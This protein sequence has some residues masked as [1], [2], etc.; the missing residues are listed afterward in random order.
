MAGPMAGERIDY[1]IERQRHER[2]VGR[3]DLM[4][5]LDQL[6]AR[7]PIADPADRWVLV[8]GGPGMGKSA[9]LAW[10]LARRER[11]GDQV[12]HHFIHR[13][14]YGWD[15]PGKL[16]GSLVWQIERRFP[17]RREP[18]ADARLPPADRL[19][20]TLARVS[21]HELVPRGERLV[22]AI[23]G[24]D[25]YDPP[26]DA[27]PDD[28]LAAFLP[29]ALPRGV[30]FLCASRS[31]HPY[32]AGIAAR[33]ELVRIDLDAPEHAAR[34][35]ATVRSFWELVAPP[36]RLGS[37]FIDDAVARAGG[38]LAHATMWRQYLA[39]LPA[40]QRRIKSVPSGLEA[41]LERLWDRVAADPLAVLGLGILCVTREAL[42]LEE[43]GAVA[44]W[45]EA[46]QRQAFAWSTREL[47][48]ETWR[49]DGQR[50]YRLHHESVR[51]HVA[52]ALGD[53][54]L[55]GHRAAL[56]ERPPARPRG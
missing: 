3:A 46:A 23:D 18:D 25:E 11:A 28:P 33:G 8:T 44:G 2:F 39:G 26:P 6:L 35:D 20:A 45:T 16:V 36:L 49:P 21:A 53:A 50:E 43:L 47:L 32:E 13:G 40:A 55:G 1:R 52:R 17:D 51:E 27:P 4:E 56:A 7:P 34:N 48:V 19:A 12:P 9:L 14:E 41:L 29:H 22:V 30:S 42:T 5:R 15:D 38:N 24:L 54:V 37:V 31:R 10:W